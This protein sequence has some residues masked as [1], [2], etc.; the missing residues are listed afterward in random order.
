MV[1]NCSK[2]MRVAFSP[3]LSSLQIRGGRLF[4]GTLIRSKENIV[5]SS[6]KIVRQIAALAVI[7]C[8]LCLTG[9]PAR[10]QSNTVYLS[11]G[12]TLYTAS[13][14]TI[15]AL[16]TV[17]SPPANFESLAFGPDNADLDTLGN[18]QHPSLLYACDT[19]NGRIYRL[20]PATPTVVQQ[21]YS[22]V[23]TMPV[24]GRSTSTGDFEFTDKL[25]GGVW[26]LSGVANSPYSGTAASHTPVKVSAKPTNPRGITQKYV[27]DPLVVDNTGSKVLR[28]SFAKLAVP[29]LSF[30]TFIPQPPSTAQVLSS[31]VGIA[32]ISTGEVFVANSVLAVGHTSF[33]PVAHFN[34]DG[35]AAG[36]CSG[37]SFSQNTKQV[38]AYL[39]SVPT[40]QFPANPANS[41][42]TDTIYLVT[43]A[44]SKGTLWSWN[45]SNAGCSLSPVASTQNAL[46]GVAVAPVAV[47]LNLAVTSPMI[48]PTPTV[49]DFNSNQFWLTATG[50]TANVTA[51]PLIPAT[52]AEMITKSGNLSGTGFPD[53]AT[54][55]P[56]LG[57]EGY[58]IVWVAHWLFPTN[59]PPS[60][61]SVFSDGGFLTTT[62]AFY[63]STL[64]NN[65]RTVKCENSN[66]TTEP[67]L[68]PTTTCGVTT[69]VGV[70]ANGP[71]PADGTRSGT[72]SVFADVNA[73]LTSATNTT[74][75]AGQF[76]GF[77]SPLTGNGII[78]PS[79]PPSFSASAVTT[80]N[81][82]FKLADL[83]QGGTCKNG[84]Y[85]T[86]AIAL[87]SVAEITDPTG[88]TVFHPINVLP[89]SSSLDQPPIF[90]SPQDNKQQYSFTLNLPNIFAQFQQF[91][92]AGAATYSITVTFESDNTTNQ[93]TL[94][95]LTP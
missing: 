39:A 45:T 55:S 69:S 33:S 1:A 13:G 40:D 95:Q 35:S 8:F 77:E 25:N 89:T 38:P 16:P 91:Q 4:A 47:T 58:E 86:G 36:T 21:V 71:I 5:K 44:S 23:G 61:T 60:C 9:Q 68:G 6:G 2:H 53:G 52:V 66:P 80:V 12:A 49:F 67:T 63:D 26:Q 85:I 57:D 20:D 30:S 92:P 19:A 46:S 48:N 24:C 75:P 32:R 31:P 74:N 93:Y 81:V 11:G 72:N 65:P 41:K 59:P 83:S 37:L 43:S 73:G 62:S 18:A 78:L 28:A 27:G 87:L 7:P 15:T 70:Y 14:G 10:A 29:P 79:P 22:A 17:T 34:R 3:H 88:A 76:C 84:P 90:N 54:P 64:N 42:I 82:K 56:G 50:C 94:F 51:T